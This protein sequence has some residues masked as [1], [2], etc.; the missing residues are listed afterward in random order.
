[1]FLVEGIPS[2][3]FGIMTFFYLPD[4]PK[5]AKFL[6]EDERKRAAAR[7]DDSVHST[8]FNKKEFMATLTD[9]KI[10]LFCFLYVMVV[11]PLKAI[12][13]F[14]PSL[15]ESFGYTKITSNLLTVPVYLVGAVATV[16]LAYSSDKRLERPV[17]VAAGCFVGAIGFALLSFLPSLGQN[18]LAYAAS[19][20]AVGGE[21]EKRI[22]P[23]QHHGNP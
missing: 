10:W 14:L 7:L 17:H 18:Q 1:M 2:I 12:T 9:Y 5:T 21:L 22:N 19:F 8:E 20:L 13:F 15:V 23:D 16:G 4:F 6:T 3:G 11:N